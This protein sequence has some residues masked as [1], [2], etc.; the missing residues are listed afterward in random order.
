[1]KH[2]KAITTSTLDTLCSILNCSVGDIIEYNPPE[3]LGGLASFCFAVRGS[4]KTK[5]WNE[6]LPQ[7]A[8]PEMKRVSLDSNGRA[9]IRERDGAVNSVRA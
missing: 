1:M 6:S 7:Y 4:P 8:A 5:D 9:V 3:D 2:G